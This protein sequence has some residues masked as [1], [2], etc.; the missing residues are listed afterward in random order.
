M[1]TSSSSSSSSS[2][3]L[4]SSSSA[5]ASVAAAA[6]AAFMAA[7]GSSLMPEVGALVAGGVL[8]EPYLDG[9]ATSNV[10][11]QIGTHAYLPCRVSFNPNSN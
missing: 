3:A 6:A 8:V 1:D 7:H 2:S 11:T 5:S 4:S 10:T 9:F